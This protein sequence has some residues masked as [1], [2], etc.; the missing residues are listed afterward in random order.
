MSTSLR[1]L[2]TSFL[3]SV[4]AALAATP[5]LADDFSYDPPGDLVT[6]S[7]EGRSDM[8]VYAP[9]MRF[10]MEE[11]PAFAN[12]QVWGHGGSQG[13]GGS[14]CDIE[15][16]SYPWHDNYCETRSWDMPLCPAG[17]GH[18]GQDIRSSTCEKEVHWVVAAEAG[19][20]TSVGSYSVYITAADGTR[21]DY[22]H[23]GQ[24]QVVVGDVVEKGQHIGKVSNEFGGSSTTVHL[25]FNLRQDVDGVGNVYV[26]PYLSLVKA[27][28]ALMG[29]VIP[30]ASGT[31]ESATCD[32]LRG[33]AFADA[34][35]A[36]PV[37]VRFYFDGAPMDGATIGHPFLAG[38]AREDLCGSLG[39]CDHGFEVPPPLSLFDG[40]PHDVHA[41]ASDGSPT[42]GELT[43]SPA[44]FTCAFVVPSG[45]LRPVASEDIATAWGFTPFWDEVEV[46][47][48]IL[49]SFSVGSDLADAPRVVAT[50]AEPER[51]YLVD[52]GLAREVGDPVT[53]LAWGFDSRLAEI[54]SADELAELAVGPA[55]RRRPVVLRSSSGALFLV[56]DEPTSDNTGGAGGGGGG[57]S[58]L[59]DD[60]GCSCSSAPGASG[61]RWLWPVLAAFAFAAVQLRRRRDR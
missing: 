42:L 16:F 33:W 60:E 49:A 53:Q 7:G 14:Q 51:L 9:D 24:V 1:R 61:A 22:L 19:T 30:P 32:S 46:S 47:D 44:S 41:F 35:A 29:P 13:P 57:G 25:H 38:L 39:S 4:A 50:S 36:S 55:L 6:G 26:P 20:V 59:T 15:N 11:G 28:Q 34:S 54:I 31:L 37:D 43:G 56:D 21:Y 10:P 45:V 23:M 17:V 58:K 18:Q 48:G 2:R 52:G 27:Y 40:L 3:V 8:N 5:A 12:S